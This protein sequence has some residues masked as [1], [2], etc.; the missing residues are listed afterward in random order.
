MATILKHSFLSRE[1]LSESSFRATRDEFEVH[2]FP[3][4]E[5]PFD[6]MGECRLSHML[7]ARKGWSVVSFHVDP[8]DFR[9]LLEKMIEA[10]REKTI[11]AIGSVL[12]KF[13]DYDWG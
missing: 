10:D 12:A 4:Y 6:S 9:T 2:S 5:A 13:P 7:K 11:Q 8:R 3:T 1:A